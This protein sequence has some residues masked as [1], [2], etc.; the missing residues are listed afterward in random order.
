VWKSPLIPSDPFVWRKDMDPAVK[1][2]I[3][4]LC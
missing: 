4:T 1:T 2:K 3:K